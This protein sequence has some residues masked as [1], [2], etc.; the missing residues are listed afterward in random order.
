VQLV[1]EQSKLMDRVLAAH[2]VY[3]PQPQQ[4]PAPLGVLGLTK[5]EI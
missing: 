3:E 2:G 5:E 4:Q 1:R